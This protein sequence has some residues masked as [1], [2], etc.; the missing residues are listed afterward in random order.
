M[1]VDF[2]GRLGEKEQ[3]WE[4]ASKERLKCTAAVR[5]TLDAAL[6]ALEIAQEDKRTLK[7]Q[8]ARA[9]DVA[10][11]KSFPRLRWMPHASSTE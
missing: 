10:S 8:V 11:G 6:E 7:E 4:Q 9:L 1:I 5:C 2:A 3:A